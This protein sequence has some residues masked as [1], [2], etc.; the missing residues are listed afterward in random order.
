MIDSRRRNR[1]IIERWMLSNIEN[2][3]FERYD[4][5]H[6]DRIDKKWK[7][8]ST[9]VEGGLQALQLAIEA[10][11]RHRLDVTVAIGYSLSAERKSSQPP[12]RSRHELL[13][14]LDWSPPSLYLF[15][16]R[17]EPWIESSATVR[18]LHELQEFGTRGSRRR[19]SKSATSNQP[20]WYY[21]EFTQDGQ[22]YQSVFAASRAA[23]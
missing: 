15:P 5:L 2:R 14:R 13:R 11:D 23:K 12:L 17:R 22:R 3:G 1:A 8:R 9:W 7:H 10:R 16:K 19:G 6:I 18:A 20:Q 4:D 21:L